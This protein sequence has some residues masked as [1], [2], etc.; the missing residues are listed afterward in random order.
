MELFIIETKNKMPRK[1]FNKST[2]K[3]LLADGEKITENNKANKNTEKSEKKSN[4]RR[5]VVKESIKNITERTPV[6]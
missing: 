2:L 3:N 6:E 5:A 1:N 4:E